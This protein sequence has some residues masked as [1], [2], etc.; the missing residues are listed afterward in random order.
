M[1]EDYHFGYIKIN[2]KVYD[3][4]VEVRSDGE[5][6]RWQRKQSHLF[7]IEDLKRALAQ[8]PKVLVFGTGDFG[9]AKVSQSLKELIKQRRIGLIINKTKKAVEIFNELL[10]QPSNNGKP[11]MIIGL[12][13]LTC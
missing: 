9:A 12:F 1:I 2:G 5:I 13:H 8:N 11:E 3:Y 6:L 4:D 7:D 10:V